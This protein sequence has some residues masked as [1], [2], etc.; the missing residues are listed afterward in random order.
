MLYHKVIIFLKKKTMS[1]DEIIK[2]LSQKI[3]MIPTYVKFSN[4]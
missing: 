2:K 4:L 3:K 1:N